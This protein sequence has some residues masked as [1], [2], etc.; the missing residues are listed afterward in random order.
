VG[1]YLIKKL[2]LNLK[3]FGWM[4]FLRLEPRSVGVAL[5]EGLFDLGRG[6]TSA[7]GLGD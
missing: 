1:D 4:A 5:A 3:A 2:V 7:E 6:I